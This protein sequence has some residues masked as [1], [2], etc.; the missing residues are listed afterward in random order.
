MNLL[1]DNQ[2]PLALA[3]LRGWGLDCVHV[4]EIGMDRADDRTVWEKGFWPTNEL[5]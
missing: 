1:V 4:S 5:L 2:L 3:H